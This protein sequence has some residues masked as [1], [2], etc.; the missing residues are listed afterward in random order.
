MNKSLLL[1]GVAIV[2]V[3]IGLGINNTDVQSYL[4]KDIQ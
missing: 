2:A 3:L 1:T 4:T